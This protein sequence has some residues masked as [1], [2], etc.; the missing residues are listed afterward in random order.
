MSWDSFT[1][2]QLGLQTLLTQEISYIQEKLS[3]PA[4]G[5]NFSEA[6]AGKKMAVLTEMYRSIIFNGLGG[7]HPLK[8]A[9]LEASNQILDAARALSDAVQGKIEEMETYL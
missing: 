3:D 2:A 1:V 5:K 7:S 9:V 8:D 6:R 4:L